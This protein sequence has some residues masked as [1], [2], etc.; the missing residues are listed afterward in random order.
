MAITGTITIPEKV[1]SF[2][3]ITGL[4]INKVSRVNVDFEGGSFDCDF[5]DFWGALTPTY[6]AGIKALIEIVADLSP[7]DITVSGDF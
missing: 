6:K 2:G 1:I 7:N 5:K 4:S 3:D